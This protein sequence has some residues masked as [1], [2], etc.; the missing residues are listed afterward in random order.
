MKIGAWILAARP[1]TLPA[2]IAPVLVGTALAAHDGV[3]SVTPALI[4]LAFALLIQVGT[5]FAND[6]FDFVQGADTQERIGPTRAVAAGLI[7]PA[8]MKRAT[9]MVLGLAFI[10][11]LSLVYW[12]GW[13][14]VLVGVLSII[15]A[16][17]YTGGPYPLGY[18]GLG[19][20]FVFIFFGL[21]AVGF[22]YYVQAGVFSNIA[23]LLG[24]GVGALSVNLLV[25]NNYRDLETDR[26]AGKRT[27]V[28]RLGRAAAWRQ[29]VGSVV[30]ALG[31]P[32]G[33]ALRGYGWTMLLP[34]GMVPLGIFLCILLRRA[35]SRDDFQLV[36]AQTA[37][38]LLFYSGLL[39][40]G[41]VL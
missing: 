33:L 14:L 3:L 5:N 7:T 37:K 1:K 15:C 19:D 34:L 8:T 4:C 28:V 40:V 35:K 13:W 18:N 23:W 41:L 26:V 27:L 24:A 11:G 9:I 6:Y 31:I 20:V 22:T 2:A 30:L 10:V 16:V 38:L 36:L 39:A 32:V 25:V 29:Y 17:A 21:V 12:G